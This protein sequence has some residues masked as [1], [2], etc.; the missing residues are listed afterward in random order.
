M[1]FEVY[2]YYY[3]V[4]SECVGSLDEVDEFIGIALDGHPIYGPK[5]SDKTHLLNSTDLD[6]CHGR[7]VNGNYRYHITVDFPYVIGC[8]I[9]IT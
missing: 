4:C 2:M 8:Y 6:L 5:A 3:I 7:Y 9:G 1:R